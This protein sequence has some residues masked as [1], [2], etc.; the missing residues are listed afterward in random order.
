MKKEREL[1]IERKW[2][3]IKL[4]LNGTVTRPKRISI[5][6]KLLTKQILKTRI[7]NSIK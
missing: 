4:I 5:K 2:V 3:E 6:R 7:L 1:E